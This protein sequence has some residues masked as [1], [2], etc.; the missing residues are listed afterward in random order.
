[1]LELEA[2]K[3][4]KELEREREKKKIQEDENQKKNK[5]KEKNFLEH[6]LSKYL[7]KILEVNLIA[8][9][10][11]RNI[12]MNPKLRYDF[13]DINQINEDRSNRVK[14]F[15]QVQNREEGTIHLWD[16]GKFSNRYYIIKDILDRYFETNEI[17]VL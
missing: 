5:I 10:L 13:K 17:P 16:L 15:I 12:T 3:V 1:M 14:I 9:E 4:R 8:K 11:K 7:P 6:K 2:E